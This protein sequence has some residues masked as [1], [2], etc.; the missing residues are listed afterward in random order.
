MELPEELRAALSAL[1]PVLATAPCLPSTPAE[2]PMFV[3]LLH[4]TLAHK[5]HVP[6][7]LAVLVVAVLLLPLI[8]LGFWPRTAPGGAA[9]DVDQTC[10]RQH[11]PTP[12]EAK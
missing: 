6:S 5:P 10:R 11:H 7:A 9:P 3:L 1:A 12:S 2:A 8:F 4:L